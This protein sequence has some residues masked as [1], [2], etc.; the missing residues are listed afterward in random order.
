[1][2]KDWH[3]RERSTSQMY[4]DVFGIA[5]QNPGLR[6]FPI[7]VPPLPGAG[8]FESLPVLSQASPKKKDCQPSKRLHEKSLAVLPSSTMRENPGRFDK[9]ARHWREL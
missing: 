3:D 7:L 5:L 2:T 8:H 6:S 4:G 9:K 1:M